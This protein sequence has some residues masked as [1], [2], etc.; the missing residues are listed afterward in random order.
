MSY[1]LILNSSN[2]I[3][4]NNNQYKYNFIGGSFDV[5]DGAELSISQITIPYSWFNIT[6]A[7]GNNT[8]TYTMPVGSTETTITVTL[9]DGFY[10]IIDLNIALSASL[11][12]NKF[13]FYS[14]T[15]TVGV[16]F[17]NIPST[18]I[19]YPIQFGVNPTN[20]A[21]TMTFQYIPTSSTNVLLQYGSGW[22][23]ANASNFPLQ[24]KLPKLTIPQ[25]NSVNISASTYG[26]GNILGFTNRVYPAPVDIFYGL[27]NTFTTA[28]PDVNN[29]VP[30]TINGNSIRSY[31]Y[32]GS[33]SN[34]TI[35]GANPAFAPIGTSVNGVIVRCNLVENNITMPSDVLDTFPIFATFGSNINYLPIA[36]NYVKMKVGKHSNL[37]ISFSDQ[38]FNPLIANDPNILISLLINLPIVK[39]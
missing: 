8:F 15:N 3:G 27:A 31:T 36:D 28:T 16:G 13:Y 14:T 38:N 12:A 11:K 20:Y 2:L 37:V 18:Q 24:P 26:I 17:S 33:A 10:T 19:I 25:Q 23:W 6:S 32:V 9:V 39:K 7:L 1:N 35:I 5:P 34:L 21:N 22:L 29:S 4:S 30:L